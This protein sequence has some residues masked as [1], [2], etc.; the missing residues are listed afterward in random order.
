V[1]VDRI[2]AAVQALGDRIDAGVRS[3]GYQTMRPRTPESSAGIVTFRK[4]GVDTAALFAQL[5]AQRFAT[6]ARSG[7]LRASP[8]FYISPEEIDRFIE[9][10]P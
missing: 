5:R 2:A 8:H 6:A 1:G 7:W 10:L 4:Q 3:K 9:A